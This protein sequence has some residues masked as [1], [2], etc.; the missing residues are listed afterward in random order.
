MP[1]S[2]RT[3]AELHYERGVVVCR[4]E[5]GER[6]GVELGEE[7]WR[8][9]VEMKKFGYDFGRVRWRKGNIVGHVIHAPHRG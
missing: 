8:W 4:W 2:K 6:D 5:L 1:G 7:T 3:L 9:E